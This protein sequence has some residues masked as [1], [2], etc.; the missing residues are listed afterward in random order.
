MHPKMLRGVEECVAMLRAAARGELVNYKGEVF[1]VTGYMPGWARDTAPRIYIGASK[2]KML[3]LSA[4]VADGVMLSDVT[5]ARMPETMTVLNST[6]Q[7][8]DRDASDFR[9]SNLYSWHVKDTLEEAMHEARRKLWVRGMLERWYISTFLDDA[10][11]DLVEEHFDVFANAYI[12][13]TPEFPGVPDSLANKLV[14]ELT[15]TGTSDKI[16]GFIGQLRAFKAAGL[17]EFG[18]RLYDKPEESIRLIGERVL[19]ALV[20]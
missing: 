11:C 6:L 15:F 14:H 5:L 9:V 19:P 4:T 16:D 12:H 2:P 20:G 10:E 13:N 17:S 3:A 18:I 7:E 8:Q 1:E